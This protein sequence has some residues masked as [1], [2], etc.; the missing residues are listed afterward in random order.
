MLYIT[1][2]FCGEET[3]LS[4]GDA[5]VKSQEAKCVIAVFS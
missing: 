4:L 5:L 2:F 1:V 3:M